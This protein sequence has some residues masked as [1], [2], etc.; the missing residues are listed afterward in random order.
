MPGK[1]AYLALENDADLEFE[2]YLADRLG[3]VVEEM[4]ARMS[5]HEFVLWSRFHA[6]RAQAK[7]LANM[8]A[9]R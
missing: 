2:F 9:Q 5:N 6:R 8:Q 4:R 7:Q 1:A 3:L